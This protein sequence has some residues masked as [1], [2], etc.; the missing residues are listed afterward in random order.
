MLALRKLCVVQA[1]LVWATAMQES[2]IG[3]RL[4]YDCQICSTPIVAAASAL[5]PH[6]LLDNHEKL[7]ILELEGPTLA[8]ARRLHRRS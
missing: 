6:L 8:S 7:G 3:L 1:L 2:L 4:S 5:P